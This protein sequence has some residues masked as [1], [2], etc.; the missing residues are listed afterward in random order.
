MG[1]DGGTAGGVEGGSSVSQVNMVTHSQNP[2]RVD[3]K[4][5]LKGGERNFLC[6]YCRRTEDDRAVG[7]HCTQHRS[8]E[9]LLWSHKNAISL[10]IWRPRVDYI[11][12]LAEGARKIAGVAEAELGP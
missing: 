1:D 2:P 8:R 3:G 9:L 6:T 5:L 12:K 7:V 11:E 10:L 4:M